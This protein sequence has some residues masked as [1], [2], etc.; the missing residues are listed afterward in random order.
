VEQP[1]LAVKKNTFA[2]QNNKAYALC[3]FTFAFFFKHRCHLAI[4]RCK[5]E[6]PPLQPKNDNPE[7]TA[8]CWVIK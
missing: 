4:P 1:P 8:A 6:N 7:H 3:L 5:N 2:Q